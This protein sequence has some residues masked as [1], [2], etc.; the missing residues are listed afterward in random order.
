MK[1]LVTGG[2]GFIGSHIVD[3]ILSSGHSVDSQETD[4]AGNP[5]FFFVVCIFLASSFLFCDQINSGL[6]RIA[7]VFVFH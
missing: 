7:C 3:G 6:R 5:G 1:I 2:A 4:Q